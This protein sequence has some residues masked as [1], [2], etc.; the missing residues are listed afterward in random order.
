MRNKIIISG[1]AASLLAGPAV[2]ADASKEE[3]IGVGS[4]AVIGAI[5]GGPVGFIIGAVIGARVGDEFGERND[6]VD[7]LSSSLEVSEIQV[8]S[9]ERNIEQL[10]GDIDQMSSELQRLQQFARPELLELMQAGIEMDL[11]FRTD[12]HTLSGTTGIR[13]Q[14][15]AAS[16]ATM[17]DIYIQLDGFADER[18]DEEYNRKLSVRR[19]GHVRDLLISNGIA[20]SRIKMAAH[21]ESPAIDDNIDSFALER[22][23]SLTLYIED[24]PSFAA[25]P[26]PRR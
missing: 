4:G 12:E 3:N 26:Q 18:G 21:G 11:L 20:E 25:T 14:Q 1:I 17:P 6:Q 13:V 15:L 24:S 16:L 10:S 7:T 23:V 8:A 22:K 2:A 19:A 9:L 5:A